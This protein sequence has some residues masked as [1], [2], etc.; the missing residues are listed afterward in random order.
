[1]S[2]KF[3]QTELKHL[4][5]KVMEGRATDEDFQVLNQWYSSF[6]DSQAFI[7]SNSSKEEI[8][9]RIFSR[10]KK[11]IS[12]DQKPARN[13]SKYYGLV[14][15]FALFILSFGGAYF[16]F[17]QTGQLRQDNEISFN[18]KFIKS[19]ELGQRRTFKLP[20]GTIVKLNSGSTI[21]FTYDFK[22][23]TRNVILSGEAFFDVVRD[24][25]RPFIISANG[26]E[27]E[28]LGTSFSVKADGSNEVVAVKSGKV[29]VSSIKDGSEV[30]LE[31]GEMAERLKNNQ[32]LQ[33]TIL[34]NEQVFGWV[35]QK[36]VFSD[37]SLKDVFTAVEKWFGVEISYP[38]DFDKKTKKYTANFSNPSLRQVMGSIAHFYQFE[39]NIKTKKVYVKP[40]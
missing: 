40:I 13:I 11:N 5:I 10:I 37:S 31:K 16:Y 17:L 1:M 3:S 24:E 15:A 19:T 12:K 36:L 4:S 25:K 28:V 18:E 7:E 32:L 20:D 6:D 27:V 8:K 2:R 39:Y 26:V 34:N 29:K 9:Q 22:Q 38:A 33:S 21:S 35:D 23:H 14:A 30:Y